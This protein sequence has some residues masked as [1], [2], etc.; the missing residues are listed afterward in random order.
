V[1]VEVDQQGLQVVRDRGGA[2]T[3]SR[4]G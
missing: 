4:V 1:G 3:W 2:V